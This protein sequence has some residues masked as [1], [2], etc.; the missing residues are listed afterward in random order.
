MA[1]FPN[2]LQTNFATPEEVGYDAYQGLECGDKGPCEEA[3][4]DSTTLLG[5]MG[6][7]TRAA[8][9]R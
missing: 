5:G 1:L 7:V 3:M 4:A 9:Q 2:F 6:E 8:S